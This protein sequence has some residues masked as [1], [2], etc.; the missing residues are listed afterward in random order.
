M[1]PNEVVFGFPLGKSAL[2]E[3]SQIT[4]KLIDSVPSSLRACLF[5][6]QLNC[7]KPFWLSWRPGTVDEPLMSRF[8]SLKISLSVCFFI[9]FSFSLPPLLILH[10][11]KSRR[12]K[13]VRNW[14][15][16]QDQTENY[17]KLYSVEKKTENKVFSHEIH[18]SRA[19][20]KKLFPARLSKRY[21][22]R[23]NEEK[24]VWRGTP[25]KLL[26]FRHFRVNN[27]YGKYGLMC[28]F[29]LAPPLLARSH[30]RSEAMASKCF[31]TLQSS[32]TTG[33]RLN[34]TNLD[35]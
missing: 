2:S 29:L 4:G 15:L 17:H 28:F 16:W 9:D 3:L 25:M 19:G 10:I 5:A 20:A 33:E 8:T 31:F 18:R 27:L 12:R 32:S 34:W 23:A 7:Y 11:I 6:F 14:I 30:E 22:R 13:K 35:G 21:V 24:I 26:S 1:S